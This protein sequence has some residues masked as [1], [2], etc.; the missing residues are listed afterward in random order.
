MIDPPEGIN[1][2]NKLDLESRLI[3]PPAPNLQYLPKR[4][5]KEI[6]HNILK[7]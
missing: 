3:Q 5:R 7:V 6:E 1:Y 2:L 4:M